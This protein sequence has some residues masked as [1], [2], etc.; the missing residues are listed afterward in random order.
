MDLLDGIRTLEEL[1]LENQRVLIRVDFNVPYNQE[2]GEISDDERIKAALPTIQ[3]VAAAGAKVILASHFGRPKGKVVPGL[4][5]EP[6]GARLSELTGYEVHLPDDCIGD[7]A[8]KVILDIRKDQVCLLENLRFHPEETANDEGFAK[9]L[10]SL[11]DVYVN[12]AFGA[13]HRAHASVDALPR[14]VRERGMGKLM[15][16]EITSLARV[17]DSPDRPFVAVLGG[18]KVKDKIGIIESLFDKCDT[19]C[20]GG[21]MANTLLAAQGANLRASKVEE[22]WFAAGRTLLEKAERR[23]VRLLLPTDVVV[24]ETLDA[25]TG[26]V[27][28]TNALPPGTMAL[29]VGPDTVKRYAAAVADAKTIFWNG[30]MGLF[31][32]PAFAAG[33]TGVAEAVAASRGFSVIGGGDSAS[34][35]RHAGEEL[36]SKIDFIST[37]GGAA[38]ELIEGKRLPGLEALRC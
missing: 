36:T 18:A 2:T 22:D 3:A 31:E 11:C 15:Q 29:D 23:G 17:V 12:D 8:R 14:L 13:A 19:L 1:P 20:I 38:L 16:K 9:E 34:A 26:Q 21:A 5:L 35:I 33:T 10:A 37:G 25:T 24:A 4:S 30:P 28:A 6:V 32:N 27:C 7:A